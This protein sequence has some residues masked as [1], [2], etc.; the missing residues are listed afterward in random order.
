MFCGVTE[1]AFAIN[2]VTY[3]WPRGSKLTWAIGFSSLGAL[4]DL[5]VKDV[6]ATALKEISECC[7]VRHEM[8]GNLNAA[9]IRV[10]SQ[11]LDGKS[12]VL[13]DCEIPVGNVS[14]NTSLRMR[15][16]DSENWVLADNPAAGTIDLYRVVLHELLHGHGLGHKPASIQAPALIAP[17]YSPLL[18]HL[19]K[20]DKDELVRRYGTPQQPPLPP[21]VPPIGDSVGVEVIIKTAQATYKAAGTAKRA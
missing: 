16:D 18:K 9:N 17:V 5:D 14:A 8:I 12:G 20:A 2:G 3:R 15:L 6:F 4:S 10:I 7:D 13:A 19:Q 21:E 1:E 11:R